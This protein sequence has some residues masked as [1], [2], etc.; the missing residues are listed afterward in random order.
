[1]NRSLRRTTLRAAT[2]AAVGAATVL[3]TAAPAFAHVTAQP[4]EAAH[5]DRRGPRS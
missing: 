1:M 5:D 3:L 4:G 2:V